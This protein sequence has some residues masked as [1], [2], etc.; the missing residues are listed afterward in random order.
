MTSPLV[1]T[2][3]DAY[4]AAPG[5]HE[6]KLRAADVA[7]ARGFGGAPV[8]VAKRP[9]QGFVTAFLATAPLGMP[10]RQRVDRVVRVC[11]VSRATAYRWVRGG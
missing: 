4:L 11:G 9:S 2:A 6:E 5:T 8:Y 1:Q 7:V 3:I 10:V